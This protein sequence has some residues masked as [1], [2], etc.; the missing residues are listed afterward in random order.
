MSISFSKSEV[1]LR[2][3]GPYMAVLIERGVP[4]GEPGQ[5][6][7]PWRKFYASVPWDTIPEDLSIKESEIIL[8]A[9]K[10]TVE[11]CQ[12]NVPTMLGT[13]VRW[14][15][16]DAELY[17]SEAVWPK[18][19]A[20]VTVVRRMGGFAMAELEVCPFRYHMRARKLELIQKLD[21]VLHYTQSGKRLEKPHSVMALKHEQKFMKRVQKMVLN[22]KDVD[23]Y[24]VI[25]GLEFLTDSLTDPEIDYVIITNSTLSSKFQR[26]ANWRTL[27][28]LRC[29]VVTIEDIVAGTVPDT[30]G[31]IFWHTTGY[32]DGGTRDTAEAIR[33]FIKW[34]SMNWLTDYV[35]LGGDTEIIP[36]RQALHSAVGSVTYGNIN[37]PD[38]YKY[39]QLGI[40]PMASSV[41]TGTSAGNVLDDDPATVWRCDPTDVDPWIRVSVGTG[42]PVNCVDLTWGTP[43]A[44]GYVVQVSDDGSNWTDVYT[45]NSGSGGTESI[46]LAC[47]SA[48]YVR[49]RITSGTN[50]AI[51]SLKVYGP[52]R[53]TWDAK[54]YATSGT[55][56]RIYLGT[57]VW[58]SA[59][60]ANTL[61]GNLILIKEGSHAGT[62]VPYNVSCN[63][64]TLGWRFVQDLVEIPGT[65][66]AP[67]TPYIEICGPSQY[68][69]QP[70]VLKRDYN[71][72][73]TDLYYSDIA[74]SEY[75]P[76]SQ[77]D[78]D[79]NGNGIYGERYGGE[80][81]GVNG[82]AD[83][84][85]GRAPVETPEEVDVFVD[86]V[87]RY[88]QF[89]Y[90]DQFGLQ[91]LLPTDFA[92]SVLLGA[93]NWGENV[94]N[95][96]DGTA[97]GKEAI[98]HDFLAH[99]PLRW[100]FTR[101]YEDEAD[102]PA[103]DRTADLGAASKAEILNAIRDGNNVVSLS[104]HGSDGYLCYLVTD[105]ID[106]VVSHPAIFYGNACLTNKFDTPSGEAFSEW[107]LLNKD[108][109]AAG[110]V[111]NTRFGWT[112]D[113][114]IELAFWKEMLN[115]GRLCE[116]FNV[117][118]Q[119]ILGWQSYSINLLGDPAMRVWSDRPK[120][121]NVTHPSEVCTGSSMFQ[122][123]VQSGGNPVKDALV[124]ATM[125]GTM[126]STDMTNASGIA[127]LTI[128]PSVAGTMQITV[129]GKN[130]IPY[131]GGVTVKK[132]EDVCIG[133]VACGVNIIC[134]TS[135]FCGI[136][137][138]CPQ[139]LV[140]TKLIQCRELV[141]CGKS[142]ICMKDI[143]KVQC[144][145]K[146]GCPKA[147]GIC[148][149]IDPEFL[150]VF[151]K[152]HDI[153]GFADL[154]E[155]IGRFDTLEV[156]RVFDRLPAEIAKPIRMMIERIKEESQRG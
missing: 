40:S 75:P 35:L 129:S 110:Y 91:F 101:R 61:D 56:T 139:A 65:V 42:K 57:N 14:V 117:C 138:T 43:H 45:T 147:I 98:R 151:E 80:L 52:H 148:P 8:L 15:P 145:V 135:V 29:R 48:S 54:A 94:P 83:I 121:I 124:C 32:V 3:Q 31:S 68:H 27:L 58:M 5:P 153:W 1:T 24:K 70:F 13:E 125:P 41:A 131:L 102:V 60:P 106:D 122:V 154:A 128:S 21:L 126:F 76:S 37:T 6:A 112:S 79:A 36:C 95:I 26:L 103:A 114:P 50:F 115:S 66:S 2:Q 25:K 96:L 127:T 72:I 38:K 12:P 11:P 63:S 28:G 10:I 116:M 118:K 149:A 137:V 73:P 141:A 99:D 143:V 62:I 77:H 107:T 123:T 17:N 82:L 47:I 34:A 84:M 16:P 7:L 97:V 146:L 100:I 144:L 20:R 92:V 132:C 4:V 113:N 51:A 104:S 109:A 86:K 74:A 152:I 46:T 89:V 53:T 108:G 85:V 155:F 136:N 130:L 150:N 87:I 30:G 133:A 49:L 134:R 81:D 142:I 93:Q 90:I 67:P 88:E 78:W 59:N 71:Y 55:V 18:V 44:T 120:Q 156:K 33:N 19:P 23:L 9:E 39:S 105:D 140:C 119:V 22:P 64:S 111:G 69:G